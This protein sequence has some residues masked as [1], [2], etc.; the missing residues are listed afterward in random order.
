MP[1]WCATNFVILNADRTFLQ[2]FC[3]AVNSLRTRKEVMPSDFGRK[4]L[5]NL[6][7]ALG[8]DWMKLEESHAN[9]RGLIDTNPDS[10][11]CLE[12]PE[13]W[14][15]PLTVEED[16]DGKPLI[17]FS[18][19][20][21]YDLPSWLVDHFERNQPDCTV[22]YKATDDQGNFHVC[23][24]GKVFPELNEID[25]CKGGD[26]HCFNSDQAEEY[27]QKLKEL[28]GI[29]ADPDEILR[30]GIDAFC[31]KLLKYNDEHEDEEVY[32]TW[33]VEKD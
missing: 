2:A 31:R 1:N 27:A 20:T 12:I 9:M 25:D 33:F 23:R 30:K 16:A 32:V 18:T 3:D 11:A 17:R 4:C 28:T 5:V 10:P 26:I 22:C 14:D 24:N 15:D 8:Y 6:A 19:Q 29:E 7:D 13:P 21:A